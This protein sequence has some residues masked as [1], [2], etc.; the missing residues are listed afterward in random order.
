MWPRERAG[1]AS[2]ARIPLILPVL[3]R[4]RRVDPVVA[5]AEKGA[6]RRA[7]QEAVDSVRSP[8]VR[9]SLRLAS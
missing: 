8:P 9:F 1:D 6:L 4:A 3:N 2:P 7:R 5:G